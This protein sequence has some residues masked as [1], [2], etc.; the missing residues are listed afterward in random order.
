MSLQYEG[1]T[2]QYAANDAALQKRLFDSLT[3]P[4][5]RQY[6]VQTKD[7]LG[8]LG[9]ARGKLT[10][11]R[12]FDL[13]QLPST[14]TQA[15]PGLHF[16][17]NL[18]TDNSPVISITYNTEKNLTAHIED[19]YQPLTPINS[20]AVENIKWK[21]NAT[22]ENL[23]LADNG[24]SN[25]LVWT[26]ASSENTVNEPPV[27]PQIMAVGNGSSSTPEG[28]VNHQLISFFQQH[29]HK[30]MGI[31]MFD[32]FDQPGNLIDTFLAI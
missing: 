15:L 20:S 26:W 19:Y 18:W 9:E 25:D 31:V 1:S 32:F 24:Y 5:A 23:L 17:P 29:K 27:W 4:A 14:Y 7:Q 12:R 28:G 8:T 3:T 2:A 11:L 30:R 16:S 6:F 13:D 10:L 21:Y 22:T